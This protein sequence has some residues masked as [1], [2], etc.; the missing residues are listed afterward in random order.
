M[1]RWRS[2]GRNSGFALAVAAGTALAQ[3]APAVVALGGLPLEAGGVVSH[4]SVN[5]ALANQVLYLQTFVN[6]V[7]S[8]IV[9]PY[10]L[11]GGQLYG[12]AG[13]LRQLGFRIDDRWLD[14][15]GYL[16]LS[17]VPGLV[18]RLD[19]LRQ[20]VEITVP[21]AQ[22]ESHR[23]DASAESLRP[24][25]SPGVVL[26][27]DAYAQRS[28]PRDATGDASSLVSGLLDLRAFASAGTV[29]QT[30][31]VRYADPQP[32]ADYRS[33][34]RLD[35]TLF[36][37][38]PERL[39]TWRAGDLISGASLPWV[40][41]V[42][43]GGLQW[44]RNFAL[45]PNLVTFP[46][47]TVAGSAAV[48][49]T[50]DVFVNN[51]QQYSRPVDP[52]PFVID[53][54]PVVTGQ[55][56]MRVVVRDALGREQVTMLPF[57]A[58]STLLKRGW[59]DYSVE[60]GW[61]RRN[62]AVASDDY[63]NH[64]A[65]SASLRAGAADWLTLEGHTEDV[66]S[67][68]NAGA[69]AV[70]QLGLLG[71]AS[72]SLA[73]SSQDGA[74]G[75]QWG[76]GYQFFAAAV[77]VSASTR[78]ASGDYRTLATFGT[79]VAASRRVTQASVSGA[80]AGG[81]L[82]LG[83]VEVLGTGLLAVASASPVPVAHA[84]EAAVTTRIAT[85][86]YSTTLRG[87][88]SLSGSVF[89]NLGERSDGALLGVTR[90][91]GHRTSASLSAQYRGSSEGTGALLQASRTLPAEGT[92]A[93]W[94]VQAASDAGSNG[95]AAVGYRFEQA[96]AEA[97]ASEGDAQTLEFASLRGS[98][99]AMDWRRW[100]MLA[101][102]IRDS[103]A[104][105]DTGVPDVTVLYE[106]RPVGR[107]DGDGL[108]LIPNLNAQ[109]R[110]VIQID[111]R[112]VPL[113]AEVGAVKEVAVPLDRSG[114]LVRFPVTRDDAALV[115]LIRLSGEPVPLGASVTVNGKGEPFV[116]GYDGQAYV[117]HLSA[118]STLRAEWPGGSCLAEIAYREGEPQLE[119]AWCR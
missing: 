31:L 96:T 44:Q 115:T 79:G 2:C 89:R 67:L 41:P 77:G 45:Q 29:T 23:Y 43:L 68:A 22:L 107:S 37:S 7:D 54:M 73:G 20:T 61:L 11:V 21:A 112:D 17:A 104:L 85:L 42:R 40:T 100:P 82:S 10:R 109:S 90:F 86:T 110:N 8:G 56:E 18:Y 12:D 38:D 13:E 33:T 16:S 75:L 63:D 99:V 116:V 35:T 106:N 111:P 62:Y 55:G 84:P 118:T 117:K 72:A 78:Q 25:V 103:F 5:S 108:L 105:V 19:T 74:R 70:A 65:L 101:N 58:A 34:V 27:Y 59:T 81:G 71:V 93:G 113:D 102:P 9:S 1:R 80:V 52:G 57:Y 46:V 6:G 48:P 76:V 64:A 53:N 3:T 98:V 94:R 24:A 30:A 92:G 50:V 83:Y 66:A 14:G 49:S 88:W 32:D 26:D 69:G 51:V 114:V 60:A 97:G 87:Q 15:S 36:R 39:D 95:G 4:A 91:F 28:E 47:P 119:P